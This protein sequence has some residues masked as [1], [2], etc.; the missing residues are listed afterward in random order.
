MMARLVIIGLA[1]IAIS[2]LAVNW[3]YG[4]RSLAQNL[5]DKHTRGRR[6]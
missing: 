1:G 3:G 5:I 6:R 2:I 4:G